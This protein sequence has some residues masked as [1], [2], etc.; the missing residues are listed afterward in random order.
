MVFQNLE[1]RLTEEHI[2]TYVDIMEDIENPTK[3]TLGAA[4]DIA[5]VLKNTGLE[6]QYALFGGYAVLAHLVDK[7]GDGIILSWRGSEDIDMIGSVHVLNAIRSNYNVT[8][9]RQSPNVSDKRTLKIQPEYA[10]EVKIDYTQGSLDYTEEKEIFGIPITVLEPFTLVR[11]KL[12]PA[13]DEEVHRSDIIGLLGVMDHRAKRDNKYDPEEIAKQLN[14]EEVNL[15]CDAIRGY[16]PWNEERITIGPSKEYT[17]MLK[18]AL[19]S[20]S[21]SPSE[22]PTPRD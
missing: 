14:P 12:R 13:I 1:G 3:T 6:H 19:K 2:E 9:D 22:F 15:L 18:K 17:D 10:P 4:L 11:G 8:N 20:R 7:Y 16:E 21:Y 5:V